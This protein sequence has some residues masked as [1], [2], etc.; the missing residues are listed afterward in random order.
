MKTFIMYDS[1]FGNTEKLAQSIA[2]TP[3]IKKN[4]VV[5]RVTET[6]IEEIYGVELLLVGSPTRGFRPTEAIAAFLKKLPADA[7]RGVK[8][9]A[10]DTRIP[11][12]SI[13]PAI[14]RAIVKRGGYAA[15]MIAKEL[16]ARG[17]TLVADP[18]GFFVESSEGPLAAGELERAVQ[19]AVAL[20]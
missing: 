3:S 13:K 20:K 10:F 15:P 2:L 8:A 12:D 6:T 4:C 14:F 19:W 9:A 16:T 18:E 11:L 5:K 7:L 17:A 1:V